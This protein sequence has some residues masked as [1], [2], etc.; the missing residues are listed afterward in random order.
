MAGLCR[1]GARATVQLMVIRAGRMIGTESFHM[2][3]SGGESDADIVTAFMKQYYPEARV[4]PSALIVP[5]LT[6]DMP[7]LEL[8]LSSLRGGACVSSPR[9]GAKRRLLEM[10]AATPGRASRRRRSAQVRVS[11]T[12]GA[13]SWPLCWA[14]RPRPPGQ[15]FDN[16]NIQG[17]DPVAS[18][19]VFEDSPPGRMPE[20]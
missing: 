18:M 2:S 3:G 6:D 5:A 11:C 19:V 10:Y 15:C 14:C 17:T 16:S 7:V 9:S 13:G 12:G 8:W 1:D 20:I 4:V